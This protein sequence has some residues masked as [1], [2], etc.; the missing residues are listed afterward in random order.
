MADYA[1]GNMVFVSN[2]DERPNVE[3]LLLAKLGQTQPRIHPGVAAGQGNRGMLRQVDSQNLQKAVL[4]GFGG[5]ALPPGQAYN[6]S[7]MQ[8][9]L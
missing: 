7:G 2:Q 3:M 5:S 4:S 6:S 8:G 9:H 1:S